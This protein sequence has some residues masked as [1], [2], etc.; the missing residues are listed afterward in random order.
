[1]SMAELRVAVDIGSKHHRVGIGTAEGAILEEFEISHDREGFELFFSRILI[2]EKRLRLPVV[3]AMEGVGGW[4]RPLDRMILR[5]DYQLINVNNVKLARF[6]EIFAAPAKSDKIDTRKMLELMRMREVLPLVF[7]SSRRRHTR[8]LCDWSSDV[9]SSDLWQASSSMPAAFFLP[10][11][12]HSF[13]VTSP[14]SG[15]HRRI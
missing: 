14:N 9:C 2:Y 10:G 3:V 13:W 4:A 7:F 15:L 1:M 11:R 6:K 12:L 5:H 8:S